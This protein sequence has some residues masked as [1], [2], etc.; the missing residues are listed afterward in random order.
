MS[1][2]AENLKRLRKLRGFS[3]ATLAEKSG[4]SQQLISQLENGKNQKTTELPALASALGASAHEIDEDFTPDLEGVPTAVVPV[5]SWISAGAML[6]DD[7]SDEAKGAIRVASLPPTGDWIALQVV[8]DS[9]DRISPPESTIIVD[10]RDKRLVTNACYVIA[11]DDGNATY[12]RYRAGP[13]RFEPVSTNPAH[14][15][16]FPDNDPIIIGRVRR[17]ILEM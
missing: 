14:E 5:L 7:L 3:Q 16:L 4:V 8:G 9:M 15:P 6:R 12:K 2:I 1:S 11:D 13:V 10:R 17:S